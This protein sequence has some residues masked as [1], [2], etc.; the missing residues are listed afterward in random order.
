MPQKNPAPLRWSP[1]LVGLHDVADR[2]GQPRNT[3][4]VWRRRYADFPAPVAT[5]H[6]GQVYT[7]PDILAWLNTRRPAIAERISNA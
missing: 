3:V 7:W 6:M 2:I 1:E 4:N 5:L